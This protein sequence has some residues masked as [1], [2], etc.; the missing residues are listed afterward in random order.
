MFISHNGDPNRLVEPVIDNG[1][2]Q[3]TPANNTN[4]HTTKEITCA[5]RICHGTRLR[6]TPAAP[7]QPARMKPRTSQPPPTVPKPDKYGQRRRPIIRL[8]MTRTQRRARF[9]NLETPQLTCIRGVSALIRLSPQ[10]RSWLA[11]RG[12][13][14]Q[15][16]SAAE[17]RIRI[18]VAYESASGERP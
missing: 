17:L 14:P 18:V 12:C 2:G 5:Y 6:L 11:G 8:P 13:T 10:A 3:L 1:S 9:V 15:Q 7:M 4:L 16:P